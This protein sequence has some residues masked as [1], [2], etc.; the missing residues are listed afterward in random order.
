MKNTSECTIPNWLWNRIV[1]TIKY[2]LSLLEEFDQEVKEF[3]SVIRIDSLVKF[4]RTLSRESN[5]LTFKPDEKISW[6]EA[7]KIRSSTNIVLSETSQIIRS[8]SSSGQENKVQLEIPL[9]P[10]RNRD[11]AVA[12]PTTKSDDKV[13]RAKNP[14]E[15]NSR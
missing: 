15:N 2:F 4:P 3:C 11:S 5:L 7:L 10:A 14:S 13:Q 1:L 9:S 8:R 6:K 12:R